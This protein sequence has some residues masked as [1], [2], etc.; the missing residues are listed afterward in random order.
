[1]KTAHRMLGDIL[2]HRNEY[3]LAA[4]EYETYLRLDPL[5]LYTYIV[6]GKMCI[7][8]GRIDDAS[9][10]WKTSV[11]INPNFI[12]GYYYLA[13]FYL[14]VKNDPDSAMTYAGQIQQ[15]GVSVMPELLRAIQEHPLYGKR[16]P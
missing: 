1:M 5:Q 16:T 3:E 12:L 7:D 2:A 9:R 15:R 10:L 13:N 8:A 6:Y 14:R 11:K 4:Q